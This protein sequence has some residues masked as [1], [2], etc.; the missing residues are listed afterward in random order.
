MFLQFLMVIKYRT[1]HKQKV[2][3]KYETP[4]KASNKDVFEVYF[5]WLNESQEVKD[6]VAQ[7][8][9]GPHE[10]LSATF[11]MSQGD[12]VLV[13]VEALSLD[14]VAFDPIYFGAASIKL[15]G[16][17]VPIIFNELQNDVVMGIFILN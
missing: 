5:I 6:V 14:L 13:I 7:F 8:L 2:H 3:L 15:N 9:Y 4:R 16:C 11:K 1:S 17:K 12:T 10:K